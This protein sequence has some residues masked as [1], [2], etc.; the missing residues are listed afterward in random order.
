M[1]IECRKMATCFH[2]Q[3]IKKGATKAQ[4]DSNDEKRKIGG[5]SDR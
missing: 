4:K 3:D 2:V 1:Q 5:L